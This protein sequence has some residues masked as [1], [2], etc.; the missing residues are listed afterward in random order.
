[1]KFGII[2]YGS[3]GKLL[4]N[5]LSEYGDVCVYV[6]D[7]DQKP[8][9]EGANF[10]S[11][12]EAASAKIVILAVGLASLDDASKRLAQQIGE[13]T[14]VVDVS[15]VKVRPVEILE[16]NLAGKCRLLYTHPL[17][18]P[19]TVEEGSVAGKNI[20]VCPFDFKGKEKI[21]D[22]LE[23]KM[24]LKVIEMTAEEH[25][26]EMAWVHALTFFVGRGIM[27]LDPPK[28][29]LTT[30]YYQKLLDLVELERQH[31]IELFNTVERGNPY[32]A[33]IRERFLSELKSIEEEIGN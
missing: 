17:F 6:R 3:F 32:A 33:E 19:Q 30:G 12:E 5:I 31:S 8:E 15:S 22:F 24:Q 26:K 16:R 2:G 18:G 7:K 4:S 9:L 27:K 11:F 13:D 10:V 20:V 21:M 29:P 14:I 1:M 25:D 28:S 23:N